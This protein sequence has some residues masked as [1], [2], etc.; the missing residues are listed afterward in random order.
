MQP[1]N[2]VIKIQNDTKTILKLKETLRH[3]PHD[4]LTLLLPYYV[5]ECVAPMEPAWLICKQPNTGADLS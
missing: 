2:Q 3:F 4:H 5:F 1:R